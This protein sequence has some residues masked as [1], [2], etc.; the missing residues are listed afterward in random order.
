MIDLGLKIRKNNGEDESNFI[1]EDVCLVSINEQTLL[2]EVIG[3]EDEFYNIFSPDL[4]DEV[5][6]LPQQEMLFDQLEDD[7]SFLEKLEKLKEIYTNV[8]LSLKINTVE[9]NNIDLDK[10]NIKEI[11]R[12]VKKTILGQDE[13]VDKV[14]S[15]VM[16]NQKMYDSDL[17]D[18]EV[19]HT[20]QSLLIFG[21]TGTGK[22]E[23]VRQVANK[24]NI[25]YVIEDATKFTQEGY[26]ARSTSDML[27]DLLRATDG[28]QDLAERSILV[29]DEIDKKRAKG[30]ENISTLAVQNSLLKIMDGGI[31]SVELDAMTGETIDFD[32]SFLTVILSGAF[33]DMTKDNKKREIGFNSKEEVKETKKYTTDDF[34]NYGMTPEFM[35]RITGIVKTNDLGYED[36]KRILISSNI[37]PLNL[38]KKYLDSLEVKY[39]FDEEFLDN[40]VKEAL[41]KKTG[42]RGLKS[43]VS[44][45]FDNLD[46]NLD[47]EVLSGD[48]KEIS[49]EKGK[50]RKRG[51]KK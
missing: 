16:H 48:I 3:K 26:Q 11:S 46:F 47:F 40:I 15:T 4:E 19:R 24:F 13:V 38:K 32:T 25:P 41:S 36:L 14:I 51:A 7:I 45:A 31:I 12:E 34:I 28:D 43:A 30:S 9:Y 49:F 20:R 39:N 37:S 5:C 27:L 44:D 29:I 23:I 35:G 10:I 17:D 21:K 8:P 22:T 2:A 18:E 33:V 42:A 50:V 6:I 1:I